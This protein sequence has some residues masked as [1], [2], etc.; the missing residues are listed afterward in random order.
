MSANAS[1]ECMTACNK[2]HD[3]RAV[4][5]HLCMHLLLVGVV[6]SWA[7][8]QVQLALDLSSMSVKASPECMTAC[9]AVGP[10]QT[11]PVVLELCTRAC[12]CICYWLE[13]AVSD[14]IASVTTFRAEQHER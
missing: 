5:M 7:A 10:C 12:T 9:K 8:L 3:V 6:Q 2:A 11:K 1:P 14:C 13:Y 4:H